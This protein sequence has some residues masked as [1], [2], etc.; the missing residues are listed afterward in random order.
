MNNSEN[1]NIFGNAFDN[2]NTKKL[3]GINTNSSNFS[4]IKIITTENEEQ[5]Q[6]IHKNN[7]NYNE[8]NNNNNNNNYIIINNNINNYNC[9][10]N[11][12][13][14]NNFNFYKN[15]QTSKK[16]NRFSSFEGIFPYI[17]KETWYPSHKK[18]IDDNEILNNFCAS[19]KYEEFIDEED[20]LDNMIFMTN[21]NSDSVLKDKDFL[22]RKRSKPEKENLFSRTRANV[23]KIY[24]FYVYYY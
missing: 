10:I 11:Y 15:E 24:Y 4:N 20:D 19:I 2:K 13:S 6:K 17:E 5:N 22:N 8:Q 21:S 12:N 7:N 23:I 18:S 1:N 9:N 3:N 14:F 16:R